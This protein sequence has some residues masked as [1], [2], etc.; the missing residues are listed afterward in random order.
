MP[1]INLNNFFSNNPDIKYKCAKRAIAIS[2]A[3][4]QQLYSDFDFF[5]QFLNGENKILKWTALRVIGNL[6]ASDSQ[7]KVDQ[8]I[9]RLLNAL[10]DKS[11]ITAANVIG[12]LAE[13][14]KN[15]PQF[16]EII[17]GSLLNVEKCV[18]YSKGKVSPE[19]R[20]VAIGHVL[21]S[22][23]KFGP[24]VFDRKE[25]QDFL[26]RQTRNTRPKVSQKAETL[27]KKYV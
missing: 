16:Q 5:P 22:L 15:K 18:Y 8:L 1:K 17:L 6:S 21:D 20:N 14:A 19:C 23:D 27:L 3:L 7:N 10:E 2:H 9:P 12:A 25:V 26:K 4:P 13:I 24:S 11:M